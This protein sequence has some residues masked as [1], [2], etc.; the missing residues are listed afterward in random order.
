MS[1]GRWRR[2]K[3]MRYVPGLKSMGS[4]AFIFRI[5]SEGFMSPISE[6]FSSSNA[7]AQRSLVYLDT[8][9]AFSCSYASDAFS[10]ISSSLSLT[11]LQTSVGRADSRWSYFLDYWVM[12]Q[13][14]NLLSF[15]RTRW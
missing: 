10:L 7:L 9:R 1:E 12:L 8:S 5:I 4:R 15:L 6:N 2:N 13:I 14:Q 11:L 3:A